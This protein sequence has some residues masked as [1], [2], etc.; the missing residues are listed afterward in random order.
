MEYRCDPCNLEFTDFEQYLDHECK[1]FNEQ[2]LTQ[3]RNMETWKFEKVFHGFTTPNESQSSN[4][5]TNEKNM[6]LM[7]D[8]YLEVGSLYSGSNNHSANPLHC[9]ISN[10]RDTSLTGIYNFES[11]L[12]TQFPVHQPNSEVNFIKPFMSS[13]HRQMRKINTQI[14]TSPISVSLGLSPKQSS[15]CAMNQYCNTNQN[16]ASAEYGEMQYNLRQMN[17]E[18]NRYQTCVLPKYSPLEFVN[19]EMN[20]HL[21]RNQ[22][23]VSPQYNEIESFRQVE[24][25]VFNNPFATSEYRQIKL[26]RHETN[27][28]FDTNQPNVSSEYS[29]MDYYDK[30]LNPQQLEINQLISSSEYS[31]MEYGK[32]KMNPQQLDISNLILPSEYSRN[33]YGSYEMNPQL[34]TNQLIMSSECSHLEYCTEE[35]NPQINEN[36]RTVTNAIENHSFMRRIS[37]QQLTTLNEIDIEPPQ[38]FKCNQQSLDSVESFFNGETKYANTKPLQQ[39][40]AMNTS[41]IQN[42]I[43]DEIFNNKTLV[44]NTSFKENSN[45]DSKGTPKEFDDS[46]RSISNKR[47]PI[48]CDPYKRTFE[49]CLSEEKFRETLNF[50]R[51]SGIGTDPNAYDSYLKTTVKSKSSKFCL[52]VFMA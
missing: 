48:G 34:D 12:Q 38:N 44:F 25:Q 11:C 35:M 41:V 29:H 2:L 4:I 39:M 51:L 13:G 33:E 6:L 27:P 18:F 10:A 40:E 20:E 21:D 15:N 50:T 1:S 5:P 26:V 22:Q 7:T 52:H 14:N 17:P 47:N 19:Y 32:Y 31:K 9:E 37:S 23:N 46:R 24:N 49:C 3:M 16:S 8:K 36:E 42:G 45:V 30:E 28:Q 43:Q